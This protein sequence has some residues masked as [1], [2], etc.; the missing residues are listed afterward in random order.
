[1]GKAEES[2]EAV[3]KVAGKVKK[4]SRKTGA[5]TRLWVKAVFTGY[6][7]LLIIIYL[8]KYYIRGK[9]TQNSSQALLKLEGVNDNISASYY[10]GKRVAYIYKTKAAKDKRQ[11]K[12][13]CVNTYSCLGYLGQNMQKAR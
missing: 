11:Y 1:M 5:P 6:R 9:H 12:V 4:I 10:F 7:R 8:N 3:K 13:F 2:K